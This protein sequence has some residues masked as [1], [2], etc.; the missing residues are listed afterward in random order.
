MKKSTK[1]ELRAIDLQK[2]IN[3][4]EP[5]EANLAKRKEL[6]GELDAVQTERRDALEAESKDTGTEHR[7]ADGLTPEERERVE[8][9][10]RAKVTE[11]ATAALEG[12][13][14]TGAESEYNA[15]VGITKS[16]RFPLSLIAPE[17]VEVRATTGTDGQVNQSSRW[18][19]RLF[20]ETAAMK[21]GITF[22]S[23]APGIANY[24]ITTAGASA[25]Q[26][27]KAQAAGDAAWTV[28]V[29]NLSPTRNAVRAVFTEEDALRLPDLEMALR[30]DL[31]MAL[32]EG[33]DRAIFIG[34][35]GA[36]PNAGDITGLTTA[37]NVVEQTITQANKVKGPETL[38]AFSALID[39]IHA[40]GFGDLRICAA[41]GA[42]RL[43][44]NTVINSAAENQTLGAFLREAGLSWTARGEI[45][46]ATANDDWGAFIGRGRGI[47]GSG[48]AAVWEDAALIRD[49]Y[50]GAAKGEVALTLSYF[51][52]FGL[53]RPAS[54]ARLKFVT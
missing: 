50:V 17:P 8:L 49:P 9:R 51:W 31:S 7:G 30:R 19:D 1:L 23:V 37:T 25:A 2:E 54:F 4:L 11:Y 38:T 3:G 10:S 35:D 26:R 32:A 28:G 21:I 33:V 29:T 13:S 39:G 14:I 22:D 36:N 12:R 42:W 20:A 45:E 18:L 15:A 43:W 44:E 47:T 53:P 16:G 5:N 6:L 27:G 41:I 48:V 52:N 34:D 24:P 40:T 46:T